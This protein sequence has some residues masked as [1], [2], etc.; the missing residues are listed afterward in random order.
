MLKAHYKRKWKSS[1]FLQEQLPLMW[2]SQPVLTMAWLKKQ[3]LLPDEH[4]SHAIKSFAWLWL[5]QNTAHIKSNVIGALGREN[6]SHSPPR[7]ELPTALAQFLTIHAA[8]DSLHFSFLLHKLISKAWIKLSLITSG[9]GFLQMLTSSQTTRETFSVGHVNTYLAMSYTS[10]CWD[11]TGMSANRI[12]GSNPSFGGSEQ[13]KSSQT[14]YP[15]TPTCRFVLS[16]WWA[17]LL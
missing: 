8:W 14:R 2:S 1:T 17:S 4:S 10:I 7:W 11:S 12:F 15:T 16:K 13:P 5:S 9:R 3:M 6:Q